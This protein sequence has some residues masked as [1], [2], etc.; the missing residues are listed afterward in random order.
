MDT[1]GTEVETLLVSS[2]LLLFEELTAQITALEVRL[3]KLAAADEQVLLLMTHPGVGLINALALVH[4]LGEVRRFR[5]KEEVVA[6]VGLDPLEK[7][8]GQRKPLQKSYVQ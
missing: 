6:F 3:A 7:S 1:A 2:R 4:T 5:R 8:S